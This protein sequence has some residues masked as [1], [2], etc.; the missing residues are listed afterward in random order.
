M[1]AGH[2]RQ[3]ISVQCLHFDRYFNSCLQFPVH[4]FHG[5]MLIHNSNSFISY[6][7]NCF[8]TAVSPDT[9]AEISTVISAYIPTDISTADSTCT[10][11]TFSIHLL[12]S[13]LKPQL[14][15]VNGYA[16][17][18]G[19]RYQMIST[20]VSLVSLLSSRTPQWLTEIPL[21]LLWV[22]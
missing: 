11:S 16:E 18:S 7:S 15:L 3:F 8:S 22:Y 9:W 17:N 19:N 4:H 6:S 12:V 5:Y 13:S 10:L 20:I 2:S 14:T 1:S 21:Q